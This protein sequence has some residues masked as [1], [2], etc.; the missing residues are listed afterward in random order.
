[1]M[2]LLVL[3]EW[4]DL[5]ILKIFSDLN[6]SIIFTVKIVKHWNRLPEVVGAPSLD[7]QSWAGQGSEQ[8]DVL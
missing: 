7:I 2:D 4:L 1:V 6:D 3:G 8:P 5:V